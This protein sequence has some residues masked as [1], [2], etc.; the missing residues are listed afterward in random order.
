MEE[1][2]HVVF[3]LLMSKKDAAAALGVCV[4]TVEHLISAKE[5]PCRKIGRRTLI[6]VSALEQFARRDHK[7]EA[8]ANADT[9]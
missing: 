8:M 1:M 2:P 4:R 6:P 5:L 7:T 9:D 3:K